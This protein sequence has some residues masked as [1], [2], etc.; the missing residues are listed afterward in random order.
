MQVGSMEFSKF[1]AQH[2]ARVEWIVP[3][4]AADGAAPAL[5]L[6]SWLL[7]AGK[8][9]VRRLFPDYDGPAGVEWRWTDAFLEWL[10]DHQIGGFLIELS[11]C[12]KMFDPVA[13]GFTVC[14]ERFETEHF[15]LKD[16]SE[17]QWK[18]NAWV[19]ERDAVHRANP[20]A[21]AIA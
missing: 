21:E 7:K 9:G 14:W 16:V 6:E 1:C 12:V 5:L 10:F 11:A 3:L 4:G 2:W 19:A 18:L 20:S 13:P 15:Y 8:A 17:L